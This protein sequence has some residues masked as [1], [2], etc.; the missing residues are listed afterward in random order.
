MCLYACVRVHCELQDSAQVL[1]LLHWRDGH[2]GIAEGCPRSYVPFLSARA[3]NLCAGGVHQEGREGC[4][5][6]MVVFVR[7]CQEVSNGAV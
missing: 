2:Q 6:K 4:K 3:R 5:R 1:P 7:G